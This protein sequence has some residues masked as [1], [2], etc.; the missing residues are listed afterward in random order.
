MN[1]KT[2]KY[3]KGQ[4]VYVSLLSQQGLPKNDFAKSGV[5]VSCQWYPSRNRLVYSVK[6]D[7][8]ALMPITEDC[9][10]PVKAPWQVATQ[11]STAHRRSSKSAGRPSPQDLRGWSNH[12][13]SSTGHGQSAP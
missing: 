6:M 7:D 9:L 4:V 2:P 5:L 10:V 11:T 3:H 1:S 13:S 8:N 12:R